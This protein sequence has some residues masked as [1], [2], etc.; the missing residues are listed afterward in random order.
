VAGVCQRIPTPVAKG[1]ARHDATA[2]LRM[3]TPCVLQ[4]LTRRVC[5]VTAPWMLAIR[6]ETVLGER[7]CATVLHS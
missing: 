5:S 7:D 1:F 4:L 3:E 2:A 6:A